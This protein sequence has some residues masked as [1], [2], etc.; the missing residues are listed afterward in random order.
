MKVGASVADDQIEHL[1]HTLHNIDLSRFKGEALVRLGLLGSLVV[2]Y[3]PFLSTR[4][5]IR[6][7]AG[8]SGLGKRLDEMLTDAE[9]DRVV[10][11]M[12]LVGLARH[13]AVAFRK[14]RKEVL[15]LVQSPRFKNVATAAD[16]VASAGG[17]GA[18][19]RPLLSVADAS[20]KGRDFSPPN[21]DLSPFTR[22]LYDFALHQHDPRCG[23]PPGAHFQI[24]V[25]MPSMCGNMW[26][27]HGH[28]RGR[29]NAREHHEAL[30]KCNVTARDALSRLGF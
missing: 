13:P 28:G 4:P 10:A 19:T 11:E 5:T 14:V 30:A 22:S 15:A 21:L 18:A 24:Q 25:H 16:A 27:P 17:L 20:E 7:F 6:G 26:G 23:P 3:Q 12:G 2:N 1:T 9:Y 8:K 29:Y